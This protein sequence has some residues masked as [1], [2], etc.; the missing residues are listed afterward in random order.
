MAVQE[1]IT[2]RQDFFRLDRSEN[3]MPTEIA[4]IGARKRALAATFCDP[5]G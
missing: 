5:Q 4:E 2:H 1:E 3:S